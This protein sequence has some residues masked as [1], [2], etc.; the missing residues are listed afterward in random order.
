MGQQIPTK[1]QSPFWSVVLPAF[2]RAVGI[3]I[4]QQSTGIKFS[5]AA[6]INN[7]QQKEDVVHTFLLAIIDYFTERIANE[8]D[9]IRT[10]LQNLRCPSSTHFR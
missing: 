2:S 8:G 6:K 9:K 4:S 1:T 10:L 7:L 3:I 5:N